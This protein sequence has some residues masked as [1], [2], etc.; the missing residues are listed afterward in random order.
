MIHNV[1]SFVCRGHFES[2]HETVCCGKTN[3]DVLVKAQIQAFAGDE[4]H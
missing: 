3:P 4:V 2:N 1:S